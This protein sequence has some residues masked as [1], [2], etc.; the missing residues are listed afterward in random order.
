LRDPQHLMNVT[1]VNRT[2]QQKGIELYRGENKSWHDTNGGGDKSNSGEGS[3]LAF[4]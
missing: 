3:K 1:V 2:T 4:G